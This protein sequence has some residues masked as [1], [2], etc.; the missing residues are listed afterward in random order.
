MQST[1]RPKVYWP[2]GLLCVLIVYTRL[3]GAEGHNDKA[4]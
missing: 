3:Y 4:R 2:V 1:R